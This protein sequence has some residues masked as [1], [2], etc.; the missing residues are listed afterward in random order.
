M[1]RIQSML[2]IASALLALEL[3]GDDIQPLPYTEGSVW[4]MSFVKVKPGFSVDYLRSLNGTWRKVL[5]EAKKQK[6]VLSYKVLSAGA[7]GRDDWDL[8]LM[9][10]YKNM[11]ALDGLAEKMRNIALPSL[12]G[13]D[14]ARELQTKRLEI[15]DI[16]ANKLARELVFK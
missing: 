11:A 7:A 1:K 5:D 16:I 3:R 9:V 10:E 14:K 4:D 6:L 15:R 13:E 12:G 8:C 2:L